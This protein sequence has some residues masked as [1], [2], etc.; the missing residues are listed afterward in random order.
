M[1]ICRGEEIL[2]K[3]APLPLRLLTVPK[4]QKQE[5]VFGICIEI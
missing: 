5:E 1:M 3:R 2:F 4:L